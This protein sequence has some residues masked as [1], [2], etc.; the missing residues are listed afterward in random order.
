MEI[1]HDMGLVGGQ[2]EVE[3]SNIIWTPLQDGKEIALKG[4]KSSPSPEDV[5]EVEDRDDRGIDHVDTNHSRS[6][7]TASFDESWLIS[8]TESMIH[9]LPGSTSTAMSE[10]GTE[11]SH[12]VSKA[13]VFDKSKASSF[14]SSYESTSGPESENSSC[15]D[16][17]FPKM[18]DVSD[19]DYRSDIVGHFTGERAEPE[20][21]DET[22]AIE[23]ELDGTCLV[24]ENLDE[25]IAPRQSYPSLLPKNRQK[26]D[27]ESPYINAAEPATGFHAVCVG[28]A[29]RNPKR[30]SFISKANIMIARV[31]CRRKENRAVNQSLV[32][33]DDK[34]KTCSQGCR[35]LESRISI[36]SANSFFSGATRKVANTGIVGVA[37]AVPF[38]LKPEE[39]DGSGSIRTLK[40]SK[41]GSDTCV[42]AESKHD[43]PSILSPPIVSSPP[44]ETPH[45]EGV[46]ECIDIEEGGH[47]TFDDGTKDV[48]PVMDEE[49]FTFVAVCGSAI[50]GTNLHIPLASAALKACSSQGPN[51][52]TEVDTAVECLKAAADI[53]D[54]SVLC[55]CIDLAQNYDKNMM[56]IRTTHGKDMGQSSSIDE[57]SGGQDVSE[58]VNMD[59]GRYGNKSSIRREQKKD[60]AADLDEFAHQCDCIDL[61]QSLDET[62]Q[63]SSFNESSGSQDVI[64]ARSE[65]NMDVSENVNM[66]VSRDS[67]TSFIRSK[68]K[69]DES[70]ILEE[71]P[72]KLP[73]RFASRFLPR[74]FTNRQKF[75]YNKDN[76][77]IDEDILMADIL[78]AIMLEQEKLVGTSC[79][80]EN[81]LPSGFLDLIR[82]AISEE[83]AL[84]FIDGRKVEI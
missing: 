42:D 27:V 80:S 31:K 35:P 69:K 22:N 50:A 57:S 66:D 73:K 53:R 49:S 79:E 65:D 7:S 70:A 26:V 16:G 1:V 68:Y 64:T 61:D 8:A 43:S 55:G 62:D 40:L 82:D 44:V 5:E 78:N 74:I 29:M 30:H 76:D 84:S 39:T 58:Y 10:D 25:V 20:E 48:S 28:E 21:V 18:R 24:F 54:K 3:W 67:G 83:V 36:N 13:S 17:R 4:K 72:V 15:D 60:A 6:T 19:E 12:S 37:D 59:N 23:I 2:V 9:I 11:H 34:S 71:Q 45:L 51:V 52:E 75:R 56:G 63:S 81:D 41:E 33:V 32:A 38:S 47:T 14:Q 46:T 77:I